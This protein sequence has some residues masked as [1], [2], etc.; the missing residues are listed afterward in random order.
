MRT[1]MKRTR[2]RREFPASAGREAK[3]GT[4][5]GPVT[6]MARRAVHTGQ[7]V[8]Y[9]EIL[10]SEQEFAPGVDQL[11]ADS[12]APV[13]AGADGKYPTSRPGILKNREC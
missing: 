2:P 8:T 6:A 1:D 10:N 11:T 4:E 7:V 5:D 3:R 9:D 13:Q 12:P